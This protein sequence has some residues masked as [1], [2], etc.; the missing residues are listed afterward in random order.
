MFQNREVR[1]EC[2]QQLK[3]KL[4]KCKIQMMAINQNGKMYVQQ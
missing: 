2:K 4:I 3:T 1:N